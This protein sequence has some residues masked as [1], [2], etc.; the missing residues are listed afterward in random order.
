MNFSDLLANL[1]GLITMPDREAWISAPIS[2][3][4]QMVQPGGVFLARIGANVDGHNLIPVA[5]ENGASAVV[6]E[7]PPEEVDC[8]VP[9]AQVFSGMEALGP[10]AAAY[11][12]YPSRKLTVIGVT[13]TDGKT[14]T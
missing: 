13:G 10:L 7:R 2:E 3:N 14:T 9:Y 4:A 5:L 6:G 12:D 8:S 11:Y 1:P